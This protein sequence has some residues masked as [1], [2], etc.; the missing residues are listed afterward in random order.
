MPT[1]P[2]ASKD[3]RTNEE[4]FFYLCDRFLHARYTYGDILPYVRSCHF[5]LRVIMKN[6]EETTFCVLAIFVFFV[7]NAHGESI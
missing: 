1:A 3:V 6:C 4:S 7:E 2:G 5:K